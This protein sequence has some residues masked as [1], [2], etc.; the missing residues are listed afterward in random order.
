MTY[1]KLAQWAQ[2]QFDLPRPP[3]KTMILD[4][5]RSHARLRSLPA[6]HMDNRRATP[7]HTTRLD[8]AVVEYLVHAE[9]SHISVSSQEVIV[10]GLAMSR[11]LKIPQS[12]FPR[13]TRAG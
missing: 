5:V 8:T 1:S 7:H 10:V 3:G 9:L 4:I 11:A 2:A 12:A 13:F 6:E